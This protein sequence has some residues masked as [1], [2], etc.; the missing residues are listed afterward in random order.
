MHLFYEKFQ[1]IRPVE[2][3]HAIAGGLLLLVTG[4]CWSVLVS[5]IFAYINFRVNYRLRSPS[6]CLN[7]K[8]KPGSQTRPQHFLSPY[9]EGT[10]TRSA[11]DEFVWKHLFSMKFGRLTNLV[12]LKL[13]SIE[14]RPQNAFFGPK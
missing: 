3:I 13:N 14:I 10:E 11:G 12:V 5:L 8:Q 4:Q 9:A 1:S 7:L 6:A 2:E